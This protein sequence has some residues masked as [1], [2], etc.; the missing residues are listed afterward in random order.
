MLM[1]TGEAAKH[2]SV[3]KKTIIKLIKTGK[4]PGIRLG[5]EWRV[6]QDDL[7]VFVARRRT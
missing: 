5:R 6:D 2:L 3:A 7:A 4:L 1:K